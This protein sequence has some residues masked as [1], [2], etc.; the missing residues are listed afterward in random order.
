MR[1]KKIGHLVGVQQIEKWKRT[2]QLKSSEEKL[3]IGLKLSQKLKGRK[4]WNKGLT[5]SND[6]RIKK[7]AEKLS[8]INKGKPWTEAAYLS[9]G[10]KKGK[11]LSNENFGT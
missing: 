4:V 10:I 7:Y 2:F 3:A 11:F 6:I 8:T 1:K 5:A 9:R